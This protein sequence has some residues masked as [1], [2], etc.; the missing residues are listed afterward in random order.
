MEGGDACRVVAAI[1]QP[2]QT[3]HHDVE[4]GLLPDIT[5]DAAHGNEGSRS[6]RARTHVRR[7]SCHLPTPAVGI[8]QRRIAAAIVSATAWA[9]SSVGA[10]TITR[11]SGSV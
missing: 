10:S 6:P 5:D 11:I 8:A 4:S 1:L 2:P 3:F 9:C 7:P